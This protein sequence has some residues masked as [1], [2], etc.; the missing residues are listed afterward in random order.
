MLDA[1]IAFQKTGRLAQ[2]EDLYGQLMQTRPDLVDPP[3]FLG[4]IAHMKGDHQQ[5]VELIEKAIA[6]RPSAS[7]YGNLAAVHIALENTE[8]AADLLQ[9]GLQLDPKHADCLNNFGYVLKNQGKLAEAMNC[10]LEAIARKPNHAGAYA[11]LGSTAYDMG[12]FHDAIRCFRTALSIDPNNLATRNS[13]GAALKETGDL[14]S[15]I[16]EFEQVL[17]S[18]PDYALA[19]INLG[20]VARELGQPELAIEY[21]RKILERDPRQDRL[22]SNLLFAMLMVPGYSQ[23]EIFAEHLRFA[24]QFEAPLRACWPTHDN[25]RDKHKR[26]KVGYVSGDFRNHAV[27][28]FIEPVLAKHDKSQVEIFC[29]YNNHQD[30]DLTRRFAALSDHWVLCNGLSDEELAARIRQDGIDILIDLSGHTRH[31]RLMTFARKPAPIQITWIGYPAT[32]GLAAMDYRI[33]DANYDPEGMTE[34]YHT[35]TL[36][37]LPMAGLFKPVA[38][39]PPIN[40]LPALTQG[41][42]TFACLNNLAK[43]TE[44]NIAL[45]SQILSALPH[46]RLM[47]GNVDDLARPRLVDLFAKYGIGEE[48]LVLHQ[49][50]ALGDFLALHQQI[51]LALDPFPYPGGT[52]SLHA[53]SMGVPVI[54]LAGDSPVSLCGAGIMRNAGLP[55]FITTSPQEYMQRAIAFA[56]DLPRLEQIRQSLKGGNSIQSA[57][58]K[59]NFTRQLELVLRQVWEKWCDTKPMSA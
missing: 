45:W 15:A 49:K 28:Y 57:S 25:P 39:R 27:A 36:L 54:T 59:S 3:H 23:D 30:D 16:Q 24:A 20:N 46:A 2:A 12:Q 33:T 22:H 14:Q 44:E 29:Y 40:A 55:E 34:R 56:S 58:D 50:M 53:L 43:I 52:T 11:N 1:A 32:T 13:L 18:D 48:R 35:E 7:M 6:I 41:V 26:L 9:R 47:L 4:L 5:A 10:F 21:F 31:N 51:D 42:F 38:N 37:R 17:A 19:Y 8:I